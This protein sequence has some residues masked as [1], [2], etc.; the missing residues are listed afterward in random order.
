MTNRFV[1]WKRYPCEPRGQWFNIPPVVN[2]LDRHYK[3][4]LLSRIMFMQ[5]KNPI[6]LEAAVQSLLDH[7]VGA[8]KAVRKGLEPGHAFW[9]QCNFIEWISSL[10]YHIELTGDEFEETNGSQL[11]I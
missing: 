6:T 10:G 5:K 11:T 3:G 4:T 9:Y 2:E 8:M 1:R 7:E